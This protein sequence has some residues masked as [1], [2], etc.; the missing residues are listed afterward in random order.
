M[1]KSIHQL[2]NGCVSFLPYQSELGLPVQVKSVG[3]ETQDSPRYDWHGLKRGPDEAV[4]LQYT[5]QGR[6]RLRYESQEY[7]LVV[8]KAMLVCVPHDHRYWFPSG[9]DEPWSFVWV[10]MCGAE[11]MRQWQEA[12]RYQGPVV[13]IADDSK[14]LDSFLQLYQLSSSLRPVSPFTISILGYQLI[15]NLLEELSESARYSTGRPEV[16]EAIRF[17]DDHI[18][19]RIGV[20]EMASVAGLSRF[21]FSRVFENEVGIAPATFLMQKR[22]DK[23]SYLLRQGQL[24][25]KAIAVECGYPDANNFGRAYKR[26][27]GYPPGT[28][29]AKRLL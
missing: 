15:M 3:K 18:H 12:L 11:V 1:L 24:S 23:A 6:G 4:I 17:C 5:L 22:M 28:F 19:E 2:D 29:R 16:R 7:E 26:F 14:V 10:D 21:H 9:S 13:S 8:G 20:A 25:V 27:F